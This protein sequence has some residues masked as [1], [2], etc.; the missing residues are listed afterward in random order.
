MGFVVADAGLAG[1]LCQVGEIHI[2]AG[3]DDEAFFI[4][5]NQAFVPLLE[6]S[7]QSHGSGGFGDDA[8]GL[9][10]GTDGVADFVVGDG[11]VF[12][13]EFFADFKSLFTG[14]ADGSAVAED[15]HVG[16]SRTFSLFDG[17]FHG[18]LV[19]TFYGNDFD[20]RPEFFQ[21]AGY[22]CGKTASS[23]LDVGA[24]KWAVAAHDDFVGQRSLAPHGFNVVVGVD[25]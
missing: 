8:V 1:D 22:G 15:I 16:Q 13:D 9:P 25:E 23:D 3:N 18:C 6:E 21:P 20:V 7:G 12:V 17:S 2:G 10:H 4:G 24:V 19:D 5:S 14:D 11:D